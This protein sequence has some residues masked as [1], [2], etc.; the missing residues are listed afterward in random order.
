M[1]LEKRYQISDKLQN[2]IV[3]FQRRIFDFRNGDMSLPDLKKHQ[4][5]SFAQAEKVLK[6]AKD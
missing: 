2:V 1:N 4:R 6:D 5:E 3:G